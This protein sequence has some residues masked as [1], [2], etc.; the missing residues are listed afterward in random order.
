MH[1][2]Q[3]HVIRK[4]RR[5]GN[6]S[7]VGGIW[8]LLVVISRASGVRPMAAATNLTYTH[9]Y[10]SFGPSIVPP[11]FQSEHRIEVKLSTQYHL[12]EQTVM[13]IAEGI[14]TFSH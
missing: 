3:C 14:T 12:M 7:L 1:F 11:W 5:S 6:A 4:E 13:L 2:F 9:I 8:V 10:S